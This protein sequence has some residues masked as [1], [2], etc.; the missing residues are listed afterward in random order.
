M[1]NRT[2]QIVCVAV[3][4]LVIV[5]C[6]LKIV[7]PDRAAVQA[8]PSPSPDPT[9]ALVID[10]NI[11]HSP[12]PPPVEP[13][14]AIPGRGGITL[15]AHQAEADVALYNPEDNA[16]WYYLT[17]HLR[18][19]E[20]GEVLFSTGLIPPGMYCTKVTLSH[21]LEPGVYSGTM[22]VQPYY[23]REP[24]TPTNN[25]EYDLQVLVK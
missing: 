3:L 9:P 22:F 20:T 2:V 24:P 8:S 5:I 14:V 1:K 17:Y 19:K 10:P 7:I 11:G 15:P 18:L 16:D 12:T 23:M 13:G 4:L 25:A 6:I 21:P